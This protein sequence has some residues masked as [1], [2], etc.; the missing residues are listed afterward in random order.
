MHLNQISVQYSPEADRLL[1]RVRSTSGELYEAWLTRRLVL[2]FWPHARE[3]VDKLSVQTAAANL[4]PGATVLPAAQPMLAQA[5]KESVLRDADFKTPFNPQTTSQPLGKEPLLASEVQ[6]TTLA[7]GQLRLTLFDAQRRSIALQLSGQMAI[8]VREL[9]EQGLAQAQWGLSANETVVE[10][11]D[12]TPQVE[13]V[14][15]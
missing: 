13:R 10:R 11:M 1:L 2:R 8:A 5:A 14:L 7:D 6:M 3:A 4:A 12:E 9:F 15:N